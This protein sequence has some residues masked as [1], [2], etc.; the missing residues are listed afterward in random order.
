MSAVVG[1]TFWNGYPNPARRGTAVVSDS[2]KFP[3]YWARDL[4]GERI[5]VV[6]VQWGANVA[7]LDDR[8]GEGWQKVTEG[9]GASHWPHREVVIVPGSFEEA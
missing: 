8:G 9:R 2:E 5:Q 7:H 3:L 6:Q 4:V 1:A